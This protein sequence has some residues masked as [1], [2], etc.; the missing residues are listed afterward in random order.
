MSNLRGK[1]VRNLAFNWANHAAYLGVMFF[2][3]PFILHT[4]GQVQYGIWSLL[5]LL[6][7]YMGVC[8]LGVRASTGRHIA[9]Y[10]GRGDHSAIDQTIR[11]SLAC[12]S[13]LGIL[14]VVAGLFLGWLFPSLFTS[15]PS[16][17]HALILLLLPLLALGLWMSLLGSVFSSV[18][19][20]HDRFDLTRTVDLLVLVLR[21]AAAVTVLSLG[22]GLYGLVVVALGR[23]LLTLIGNYL[24]ARRTYPKLRAW[25]PSVSRVRLR[26]LFGYGLAAF[27]SAVSLSIVGQ[28]NMVVAGATIDLSS[29]AVYSVGAMLVFYS[30]TFLKQIAGTLFPRIQ[31]AVA[32]DDTG[33][34]RW[35][36][37]RASRLNLIFGLLVYGGMIGFAE[38]FIRLWMHGPE[39]NLQSVQQSATVMRILACSQLLL[40]LPGASVPVLNAMGHV[41]LT[42][43]LAATEAVVNLGLSL[44]FVLVF[45]WGLAGIAGATLV[46]R[47]LI[48]TFPAPWFAC[49]KIGANWQS[50]LVRIGGLGLLA[51]G[52]MVALCLIV[53]QFV[54][55]DSW[56]MFLCGVALATL[57]YAVI[58][59]WLLVPPADRRR[60]WNK[61]F[62]SP[63]LHESES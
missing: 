2:L 49:A 59:Y 48:G 14:A 11:T 63:V 55:A 32:R 41:R 39:F 31:R 3:S 16:D 19:T 15:V 58:A 27:V 5:M 9:L 28:T 43:T 35:L 60:V 51:G 46:A 62:G 34:A 20:A 7:G 40:L 12:L 22:Y 45:G 6:T 25:P 18:L 23:Q 44:L 4:L 1:Y 10:V 61:C 13:G 56:P 57:G 52:L 50:Y 21:V 8:D 42:A 53:R 36:F 24:L 47:L 38:P 33:D 30:S 37:L 26:E 29:V 54:P 17:F